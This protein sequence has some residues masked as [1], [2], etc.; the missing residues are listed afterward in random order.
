MEDIKEIYKD[1]VLNGYYDE[2]YMMK[3]EIIDGKMHGVCLDFS[4]K[5][6][7]LFREEGYEAGLISTLNDDGTLH[8]AVIYK[9]LD[10][11]IVGIADPV[12]DVRI[13]T[14]LTDEERNNSIEE[15]LSK[16]NWKRD[17]R[18]YIRKFGT[19]TAYN[20]DLSPSMKN[21]Q[22]KE[23]LEAIP[24]IN[25]TIVKKMQ[26]CQRI[27]SIDYLKDVADGPT[28]LACQSLYKKG[29]GTYC[30]NYTPNEDVSINFYYNSLSE[31]NKKIIRELQKEYPDS[32][33]FKKRD[34]FYGSLGH[35]S[36]IDE[37]RQ[38]EV[39]FGMKNFG[40]KTD[41]QINLEMNQLISS[42]KKQPYLQDSYTR[43]QMLLGCN[44]L[45][46]IFV[47][48]GNKVPILYNESDT[49]E[50]IAE[51]EGYLYSQKY[52]RFFK[53][54]ATKS[55]Y[56]ESIFKNEHELRT[57]EEVAQENGVPYSPELKMFF[58]SENEMQQYIN[59]IAK[60]EEQQE[61]DDF[62]FVTPAD[63]AQASMSR[64]IP[65]SKVHSVKNFIQG[66][67][68]KIKGNEEK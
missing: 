11:D 54:L 19:V 10:N 12:T 5:L 1:V 35:S 9:D 16:G 51:K 36:E 59:Q 48:L 17:L 46:D 4:R 58:E 55:R 37:N 38:M 53:N 27:T 33:Y 28:L 26:P 6:I 25:K 20:D 40:G 44:H 43:E 34:G 22:D 3:P 47:L 56:I 52:N 39:F 57:D 42:L 41:A 8:A 24:A 30:S 49:N 62:E 29:I 63:I 7:E 14:G 31:E 64:K 61:C 67:L 65:Q 13:L 23:E 32:F 45:N 2:K 66:L 50:Q 18:E 21:I 15:I 68:K 60:K